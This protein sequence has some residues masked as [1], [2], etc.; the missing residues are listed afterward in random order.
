[1]ASHAGGNAAVSSLSS[2]TAAA[3]GAHAVGRRESMAKRLSSPDVVR[4]M[5]QGG[6]TRLAAL[7]RSSA[8][9]TSPQANGSDADSDYGNDAVENEAGPDGEASSSSSGASAGRDGDGASAGSSSSSESDEDSAGEEESDPLP[10]SGRSSNEAEELLASNSAL[11]SSDHITLDDLQELGKLFQLADR[12]GG[13]GLDSAEFARAF[14]SVLGRG[15]S[16]L[17]LNQLFMKIDANSDGTV[18]WAEFTEYMLLENRGGE[19]MKEA[20]E[21]CQYVA[22]GAEGDS[23]G[24]GG[25]GSVRAQHAGRVLR[26]R[27]L[28][29][30]AAYASCGEDGTCRLWTCK[31]GASWLV[32]IA[33]RPE[34][35]ILDVVL[36]AV[37]AGNLALAHQAAEPSANELRRGS[38]GA[39]CTDCVFMSRSGMLCVATSD[40]TLSFY[41]SKLSWECV[42]RIR[43]LSGAPQVLGYYV[44]S[45]SEGREVLVCADDAGAVHVW[46]LEPDEWVFSDVSVNPESRAARPPGVFRYFRHK[47]HEDLIN[48]MELDHELGHVVTA[49]DD[50]RVCFTGLDTPGKLVRVF[51]GHAGRAVS[52]VC[53]IP[54]LKLL[55]SGGADRRVLLWNP[56]TCVVANEIGREQGLDECVQRL[57]MNS[58]EHQL[59]TLTASSA[60]L[61]WDLSTLQ[62][63][64]RILE[65][66]KLSAMLFDAHNNALVLADRRLRVRKAEMTGRKEGVRR[67]H[68]APVCAC[69]YNETFH[70]LVSAASFEV[71]VWDM[72]TGRMSF[73]FID[74]HGASNLTALCFDVGGRRLVS[75]A[76]DG[77]LKIWN[78]N[79]GAC[80]AELAKTRAGAAPPRL[81]GDREVT[82]IT[83]FNDTVQ[84]SGHAISRDLIACAGR[85]RRVFIF[86]ETKHKKYKRELPLLEYVVCF[87]LEQHR[88]KAHDAHVN[89]VVYCGQGAVATCGDDGLVIIWSLSS[90]VVKQRVGH[91]VLARKR[92]A[93]QSA[94]KR[95]E[96]KIPG[97]CCSAGASAQQ[98]RQLEQDALAAQADNVELRRRELRRRAVRMHSFS[99]DDDSIKQLHAAEDDHL[100]KEYVLKG[101]SRGA[102]GSK[103]GA[104]VPAPAPVPV[105]AAATGQLPAETTAA[106]AAAAAALAV[107]PPLSAREGKQLRAA[108]ADFD[109][110]VRHAAEQRAMRDVPSSDRLAAECCLYLYKSQCL[111]SCGADG[112]LRFWAVETGE[113]LIEM[114]AGHDSAESIVTLA[115]DEADNEVLISGDTGGHIRI[116]DISALKPKPLTQRGKFTIELLYKWRAHEDAV[117]NVVFLRWSG[118]HLTHRFVV[119]TSTDGSVL[120]WG[121]R[122]FLVGMFGAD[123]PWDIESAI[124]SMARSSSVC[125]SSSMSTAVSFKRASPLVPTRTTRRNRRVSEGALRGQAS[126]GLPLG[127]IL[128]SAADLAKRE[129]RE[130][131]EVANLK[132]EY[133][134]ALARTRNHYKI[135]TLHDIKASK[136]SLEAPMLSAA[137]ELMLTMSKHRRK[138]RATDMPPKPSLRAQLRDSQAMQ[139]LRLLPMHDIRKPDLAA[140]SRVA[141]LARGA[142]AG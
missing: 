130:Q 141:A 13:G 107:D 65:L 67:S 48:W 41:D 6:K 31:E 103:G 92:L 114:D 39:W 121:L 29:Q 4:Q 25:G 40:R 11:K 117:V 120:L 78:F 1:M 118:A 34:M 125:T 58:K 123:E 42:G 113:M 46:H 108:G 119:T 135:D 60:V 64:Q 50:G 66:P 52:C 2:S 80:L 136:H 43:P 9:L 35:P 112:C 111:V 142:P 63:V 85:D 17:Q 101:A 62:C 104:A 16:K 21:R 102:G 137:Q 90:G 47:V 53:S 55:A 14:G 10:A 18:D 86:S 77:S 79:N 97:L 12:D 126:S 49:G 131:D 38:R 139:K 30:V 56:Y 20:D 74:P 68:N 37:E 7:R 71:H 69:A 110:K 106:T 24:G 134:V 23:G 84:A 129:L 140:L 76:H 33:H 91:S 75:G 45:M 96:D 122:G 94:P 70:Q 15:L 95:A 105:Q 5:G 128:A 32:T 3:G 98:E 28:K 89:K 138:Q 27:H 109:S 82:S 44:G 22:R 83:C 19:L 88:A 133:E 127:V 87:P 61:V 73:R 81:C 124:S 57:A 72:E 99:A 116:W 132:D 54:R 51:E 36:R 8:G 115:V 93:D 26:V 100:R 59:L